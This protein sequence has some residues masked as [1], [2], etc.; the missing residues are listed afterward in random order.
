M[1]IYGLKKK[2]QGIENPESEFLSK[3]FQGMKVSLDGI[4]RVTHLLASHR[5][6]KLNVKQTRYVYDI[7]EN[8]KELQ[9]LINDYVDLAKIKSGMLDLNISELDINEY[10]L[11]ALDELRPQMEEKKI[12]FTVLWETPSE[13]IQ[14]DSNR[15]NQIFHSLLTKAVEFSVEG[16][17]IF[18]KVAFDDQCMKV[19]LQSDSSGR[20]DVDSMEPYNLSEAEENSGD[21]TNLLDVRMTLAKKLIEMHGG[22]IGLEYNE[23]GGACLWFTISK[24]INPVFNTEGKTAGLRSDDIVKPIRILLVDDSNN[25]QNLVAE[26]LKIEKHKVF[27]A[28]NGQVGLEMAQECRPDMIFMDINMPVMDG[29]EAIRHF[30]ELA[31]FEKIPIVAFTAYDMKDSG[32]KLLRL[33]FTRY[34]NKPFCKQDLLNTIH[35]CL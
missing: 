12:C 21:G 27:V 15:L 5:S 13:K 16:E 19:C 20:N 18:L 3:M 29:K 34:L 33:G 10:I 1:D 4:M 28:D 31:G 11:G 9:E 22:D 25:I 7:F 35:T 8:G 24:N 14:G 6:G 32:E 30:R 26:F 23:K 2:L 17:R